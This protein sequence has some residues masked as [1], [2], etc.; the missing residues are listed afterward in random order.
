[1][2]SD[3]EE[4]EKDKKGDADEGDNDDGSTLTP[5]KRKAAGSTG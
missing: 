1:V 2:S 4:P 5:Q 3:E